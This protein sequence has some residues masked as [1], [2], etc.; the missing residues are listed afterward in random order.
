[1]TEN[2]A[3]C[4]SGLQ[5]GRRCA[6]VTSLLHS[7][8]GAVAQATAPLGCEKRLFALNQQQL[9]KPVTTAKIQS[10]LVAGAS[11]VH[12]AATVVNSTVAVCVSGLS[13]TLL[14]VLSSP[15]RISTNVEAQPRSAAETAYTVCGALSVSSVHPK[16]PKAAA[17]VAPSGSR[18]PAMN[19]RSGCAT[20]PGDAH[21]GP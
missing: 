2:L 19:R 12:A 21:Y 18:R 8:W 4:L 3:L 10:S 16:K 20:Q 5:S 15:Q 7:D 9:K 14:A 13:R 6:I 17:G 1:M 11:T